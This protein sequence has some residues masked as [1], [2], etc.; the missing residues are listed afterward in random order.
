MRTELL[1]CI[2]SVCVSAIAAAAQMSNEGPAPKPNSVLHATLAERIKF[3]YDAH[4]YGPRLNSALRQ[5]DESALRAAAATG[6]AGAATELWHRLRCDSDDAQLALARMPEA[7]SLA[8]QLARLTGYTYLIYAN[9][10]RYQAADSDKAA[11][12][13]R[14]GEKLGDPVCA[15]AF[16]QLAA[17]RQLD[18][19]VVERDAEALR[20]HTFGGAEVGDLVAASARS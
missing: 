8:L 11:A 3:G 12:W 19:Q 14:L 7:E 16:R 15:H 18:L 5:M 1:T 4:G 6:D 17:R 10:S 9:G 2:I 20:A 13:Y